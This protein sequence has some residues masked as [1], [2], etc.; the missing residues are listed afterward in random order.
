M[1]PDRMDELTGRYLDGF[2]T[3][4]ERLELEAEL[5]ASPAAALRF[6]RAVRT[7]EALHRHYH[8]AH[9]AAAAMAMI[10]EA[11]HAP[12]PA[13]ARAAETVAAGWRRI[14]GR[15]WD[16]LWGPAGAVALH[17]V[18][19]VLLVRW[20]ASDFGPRH[21]EGVSVTLTRAETRTFDRKPAAT[22]PAADVARA[23][24]GLHAPPTEPLRAPHDADPIEPPEAPGPLVVNW[25]LPAVAGPT[26]GLAPL[27]PAFDGR[28][29]ERRSLVLAAAA[30]AGMAARVEMAQSRAQAWLLSQ[31]QA[32]G[33]WRGPSPVAGSSLA[34]LALLAHAENASGE[35]GEAVARAVRSLMAAQR[36]PGVHAAED[37][38]SEALACAALAEYFLLTRVPAV[39]NAFDA[40]VRR[41]LEAQDADGLWTA[42]AYA[43]SGRRASGL[44]PTAWALQALRTALMAGADSE[45]IVAAAA[46]AADGLDRIQNPVS[47]LYYYPSAPGGSERSVAETAAAVVALQAAGRGGSARVQRGLR[48]MAN[49]R[50]RWP[51]AA[52]RGAESLETWL[53]VSSAQRQAGAGWTTAYGHLAGQMLDHQGSAG[54]WLPG[55]MAQ[56]AVAATALGSLCLSAPYRNPTAGELDRIA[57]IVVRAPAFDPA[58]W[59]ILAMARTD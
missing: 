4:A 31:Q 3:D 5:R 47:G 25:I 23:G 24:D 17:V 53:F 58:G 48:A 28:T 51:D 33:S 6:V 37:P 12:K 35:R 32:D 38:R 36:S 57:P 44:A 30:G 50:F 52:A 55:T 21:D 22:E 29:A 26:A 14:W 45:A 2:A 59:M 10:R 49:A 7:D 46:R 9:A 19:L 42:A 18:L 39:R 41:L 11:G 34:I 13:A 27:P 56:Q 54:D 16:H 15:T 40:S 43:G 20:V 1:E 8:R